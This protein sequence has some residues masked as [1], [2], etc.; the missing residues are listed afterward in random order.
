M[1]FRPVGME[2]RDDE[3]MPE[4]ADFTNQSGLAIMALRS[5]GPGRRCDGCHG[6]FCRLPGDFRMRK[7]PQ[8]VARA[9]LAG[10]IKKL[11]LLSG[12]AEQPLLGLLNC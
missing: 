3:L 6:A 7:S 8:I 10:L 4:G 5:L 12:L 2:R 9:V 11:F 1:L